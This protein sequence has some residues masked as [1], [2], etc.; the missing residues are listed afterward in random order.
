M[1]PAFLSCDWG[2]SSFR[3]RL[4]EAE[5]FRVLAEER[6]QDG[7]AA[8]RERAEAAGLPAERAFRAA[9]AGAVA[10]LLSAACDRAP[11]GGEPLPVVV[12]GMAS[13]SIG[14]R[15][16]PYARVP[17]PLD[18][19][20]VE[21][22]EL[23]LDGRRVVLLS[24]L[25]TETDVLRGEETE[26]LG[27]LSEPRREPLR[28]GALLV[29]PGTHSKHVLVEGGRIA[30]FTTYMTGELYCVLSRQSIL[31]HS[32]DLDAVVGPGA[33]GGAA[34]DEAGDEVDTRRDAAFLEG[35]AAARARPLAAALFSVRTNQLLRGLD[36][37]LNA[38][39]LSG[40]LVGA[41]AA[42]AASAAPA[43]VPVALCA[44][45]GLARPYRLAFEAAGL[46]ARLVCLP[47]EEV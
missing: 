2:T 16:L 43:G 28:R 17:F 18:G 34:G 36:P 31:R 23:D 13:S 46:G 22:E 9:L 45:R 10:R 26:V 38:A 39:Y 29:L 11:G 1:S 42:A 4:V 7:A 14:W 20:R 40:L 5:P 25:R 41:E 27:V 3:L 30:D 32:V 37:P 19:S 6:S 21:R 35:A 15:E 24:G 44:G 33:A 8:V 12:S 47:P